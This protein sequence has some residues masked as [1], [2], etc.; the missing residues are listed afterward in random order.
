MRRLLLMLVL[1]PAIASA[2]GER[3]NSIAFNTSLFGFNSYNAHSTP[4]LPVFGLEYDR[5]VCG[6]WSVG[7]TGM[8]AKMR[9]RTATDTYTMRE[10]FWFAGAKANYTLPVVRKWLL[11]R[12]GVGGGAGF[13]SPYSY[14]GVSEKISGTKVKPHAMVDLYMV[15]RPT[16]WLDLR[17]SPLLIA[18]SQFIFGSRFDKPHDETYFYW[19]PLG[20]LG[21]SVRF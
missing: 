14:D 4:L 16:R 17:I 1:L 11:L 2:Q 9:S 5:V 20:T 15:F 3:K 18:P 8:Y 12:G 13:H 21:V 19:N 10:N 7:V 6:R